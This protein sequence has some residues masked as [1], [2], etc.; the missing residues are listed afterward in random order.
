MYSAVRNVMCPSVV[1]FASQVMCASRVVCGIHHIAAT[2]VCNIT[3]PQ[4]RRHLPPGGKH[5]KKTHALT[6]YLTKSETEK[7][8][9]IKI[10]PTN[11]EM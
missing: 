8:K 9:Q 2:K 11:I 4:A 3:A 7:S 5:H 1:M 6:D 10:L